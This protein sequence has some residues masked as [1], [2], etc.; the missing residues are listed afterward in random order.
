MAR[1][2]KATAD[3]R[4]EV[5][6]MVLREVENQIIGN[7]MKKFGYLYLGVV[8]HIIVAVVSAHYPNVI[9]QAMAACGMDE[10]V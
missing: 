1:T 6:L 10:G 8:P 5:S 9:V 3:E 4:K 7:K 2:N